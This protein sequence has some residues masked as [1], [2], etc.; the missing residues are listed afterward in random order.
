MHSSKTSLH[1]DSLLV[2]ISLELCVMPWSWF[3][4]VTIHQCRGSTMWICLF[5]YVKLTSRYLDFNSAVNFTGLSEII[6]S[7]NPARRPKIMMSKERHTK[8]ERKKSMEEHHVLKCVE[9]YKW[10]GM[11]FRS[12]I[13]NWPTEYW[14]NSHQFEVEILSKTKELLYTL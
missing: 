13:R 14:S 5:M 4:F 10:G 1:R 7:C 11:Y 2:V 9:Q 6:A 8:R 3:T 12:T